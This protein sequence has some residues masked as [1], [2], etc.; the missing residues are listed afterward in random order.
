[1]GPGPG[2]GTRAGFVRQ[3]DPAAPVLTG[4]VGKSRREFTEDQ[5][6]WPKKFNRIANEI[7]TALMVTIALL[8][9]VKPF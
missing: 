5:N 2:V 7:P 9:I 4:R 8:V 3:I 6:G 1:M